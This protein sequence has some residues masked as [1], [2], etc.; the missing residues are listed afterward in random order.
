[1]PAIT[2]PPDW[3]SKYHAEPVTIGAERFDSRGEAD[4]W[5]ELSY[6]Q[7]AGL[8]MELRRQV[9]FELHAGDRAWLI[10]IGAYVADFTYL[11]KIEGPR[12]VRWESVV[13]D[14]KGVRTA[15]YTWKKKHVEAEYH[16]TV[17]ETHA[18]RRR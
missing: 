3:P 2:W 14:F 16:L 10:T 11:E 15:L 8:V 18:A 17:R 4:R 5:L 7:K 13:E 1:M 6:L 12:G 9:R